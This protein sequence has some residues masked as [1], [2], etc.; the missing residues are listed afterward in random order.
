MIVPG[1][2]AVLV[3]VELHLAMPSIAWRLGQARVDL[4]YYRLTLVIALLATVTAMMS[5]LPT[6][7]VVGRWDPL[8]AVAAATAGAVLPL[9][10]ALLTGYRGVRR[11]RHGSLLSTVSWIVGVATAEE[12]LWRILAPAAGQ[13]AGWPPTVAIAAAL[14]G[15]LLLHIPNFGFRRLPYLATAGLLFTGCALAGGLLAAAAAHAVHNLVIELAT[16]TARQHDDQTQAAI[17]SSQ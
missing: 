16:T 4:T 8:V 14:S 5:K 2:A 12:I 17:L 7:L 1:A 11:N 15:F 6:G 10:A 13:A 9:A 3:V